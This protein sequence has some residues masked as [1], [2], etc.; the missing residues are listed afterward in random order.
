VNHTRYALEVIQ[1]KGKI[2]LAVSDESLRIDS[3][4]MTLCFLP[5]LGYH[6]EQRERQ[7]RLSLRSTASLFPASL[8]RVKQVELVLQIKPIRSWQWKP[9]D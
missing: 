6:A 9:T 3:D 4:L 5:S 1:K 2:Y 8:L 7:A